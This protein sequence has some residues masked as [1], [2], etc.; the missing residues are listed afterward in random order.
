[1]LE[2][3]I[4]HHEPRHRG[5]HLAVISPEDAETLG[6]SGR[7]G[8][9]WVF[10]KLVHPIHKK[11][12]YARLD[13]S[14]DIAPGTIGLQ[15]YI[16]Y[17]CAGISGDRVEVREWDA[18]KEAMAA[19]TITLQELLPRRLVYHDEFEQ[20]R[21]RLIGSRLPVLC[22]HQF[23][24]VAIRNIE[25]TFEVM[26]TS[27]EDVPVV[28]G[29]QTR[30][31]LVNTELLRAQSP[32]ST[33]AFQD[34]GGLENA[35]R[36]ITEMVLLPAEHPEVFEQLGIR[37]PKGI[38]LYGPPGTGKTL[39]ARAIANAIKAHFFSINGPEILA[40]F[41]GESERR[42]RD[43]FAEATA[44]APSVVFLDELDAIAPAREHVSGDLEVRIVS[45][46]LTLMDGL[47]E[48]GQVV[49]LAA[50]NRVGAVDP[51][52]RRPGRFDREIEIRPPIP[53]ERLAILLVHTRRMPLAPDIDLT[54]IADRTVGYVGADLAALCQ[55]AALAAMRRTFYSQDQHWSSTH[56]QPLVVKLEDFEEGFRQV[57][58]SAFRELDRPEG[59]AHWEELIGFEDLK[60]S[61]TQMI[62]WQLYHVER[63]QHFGITSAQSCLLL[64]ASQTGKTSFITALSHHL[65]TSLVYVRA[66]TFLHQRESDIEYILHQA[67][68]KARQT[69]PSLLVIDNFEQIF[70]ERE[71]TQQDLFYYLLSQLQYELSEAQHSA[72]TFLIVVARTDR[73][74]VTALIEQSAAF[75]SVVHM[76]VLTDSQRAQAI[77]QKIAH[78]LAP[79]VSVEEIAQAL[80]G[81][82]IGEVLQVCEHAGKNALREHIEAQYISGSHIWDAITQM[83]PDFVAPNI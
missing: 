81:A 18:E 23:A 41:Y 73:Q 49:V 76:P 48:R 37:P 30:F 60:V 57:Q 58:P 31:T 47:S 59:L 54:N 50:T 55:E 79:D 26:A 40:K 67:F 70:F 38:L 45:Q 83:K 22:G 17:N 65:N 69:S 82:T 25:P 61:F 2:L 52:L 6:V 20:V 34:I 80:S 72:Q 27:P 44:A 19:E 66:N 4:V 32:L 21:E 7:T 56:G 24:S 12:A 16:A 43:L 36:K 15:S 51:A 46:L 68:R 71:G 8:T 74:D 1:V 63:L 28:C 39:L 42:L 78:V 75:S 29:E 62:E 53:A 77:R 64:G 35:I 33:V 5:L 3:T 9:G 11:T 13:V 10:V 14:Q